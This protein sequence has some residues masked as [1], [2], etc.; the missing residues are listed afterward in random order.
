MST[1]YL[2]T[3]TF[4]AVPIAHGVHR[5]SEG[6]EVMILTYAFDDEDV[7]L[8][9]W[10]ARGD[11]E[12]LL[13]RAD[14][15]VMHNSY[16]DR[17]MLKN[18]LS[19]EIPVDKI[20]D[21]MAL[22]LMHGLPGG[23]GPLSSIMRLEAEDVKDDGK[24]LIHLFCKPQPKRNK[25]RRATKHTHPDEWDKFCA[26]AKKDIVAMRAL[27]RKLPKWNWNLDSNLAPNERKIWALDQ[28]INDRGFAV[29]LDL[30]EAAN[31]AVDDEKILLAAQIQEQTQ[32][33]VDNANR[34]AQLLE[35]LN[36]AFDLELKNLQAGVLEK[37][38]ELGDL[39]Q[40]AVDIIHTRLSASTTSVAKYKALSRATALDGRL[41]GSLQYCGA[42]RTGR[43][44]GR[45]FQPQNLPRPK[46]KAEEIETNIEIFKCGLSGV[47][48]P[49]VMQ[50]ASDALRGCI[51]ATP[52]HKLVV[53]DLS[54][55]EGRMLAWLA[56]EQWKLDA[57]SDFDAGT[58]PD[59]YRLAYSRSFGVPVDQ[60]S[61]ED[62]Q[63]GK[64]QE[65]ALGYQGAVGAFSSMAALYGI[66]L[67]EDAV[68]GIVKAWR[69]A[70]PAVVGF[71]YTMEDIAKVVTTSPPGTEMPVESLVLRREP[72][73]LRVILPSGRSLC[74][75]SPRL[76]Q[77]KLTYMGVNQYTRK[78]SRLKTYGG[79]LVENVTQA[80]ARD[81]IA[82]SAYRAEQ[83]AYPVVLTVH[84]EL[85]T[86]P[87]DDPRFTVEGLCGILSERPLWAHGLPLA[88]AGFEGYRYRKD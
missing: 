74:Y 54:N 3:E 59:L 45:L 46:A 49:D 16:F 25:I 83:Q 28:A 55:I 27:I 52:G 4:S 44:A 87:K 43:W 2:D 57:F 17:T 60:V 47:L 86:E 71:W 50:A 30:V 82:D 51:V 70:H 21:T 1:L 32:G 6:A 72:A 12:D 58:G 88:A 34:R 11:V 37:V 65:L 9:E 75:A 20:V 14:R 81:V 40:E 41:R 19:V 61:K 29:D 76:E 67:P 22:A 33:L 39:P 10:P 85:I 42:S 80:A 73:W 53:A 7:E 18:V 15:I 26:Y 48:I 79:K 66:E 63:L 36:S 24:S 56:G 78:W 77:G 38:V 31:Q 64:V 13:D 62:R 23:L 8:I 68:L 69:K 5:Y 84:D 35:Y